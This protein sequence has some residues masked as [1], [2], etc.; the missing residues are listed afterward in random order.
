MP[1]PSSQHGTTVA[2]VISLLALL[3]ILIVAVVFVVLYVISSKRKKVTLRRLQLDLL[4][5][6]LTLMCH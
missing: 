1:A 4:S 5:R 3:S 6:Y 2:I